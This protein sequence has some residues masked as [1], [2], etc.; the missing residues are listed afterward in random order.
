MKNKWSPEEEAY[1]IK[2]H[3]KKSVKTIAEDLGR[4]L[5]SVYKAAGRL[6]AKGLIK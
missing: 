1:L 4:T 5:N 2:F 6:K 3:K